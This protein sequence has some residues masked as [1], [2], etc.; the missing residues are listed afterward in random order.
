MLVCFLSM[1]M[2]ECVAIFRGW[3]SRGWWGKVGGM[4][5]L[6]VCSIFGLGKCLAGSMCL[7]LSICCKTPLT[8]RR[9]Q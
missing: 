6:R 4:G 1:S 7:L 9:D 3:A 8:C 2:L 5:C